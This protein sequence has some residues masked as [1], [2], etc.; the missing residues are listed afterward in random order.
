MALIL[1]VD[2]SVDN[3]M[4]MEEFLHGLEHGCRLATSG[5]MAMELLAQETFALIITDFQMEK[6]DGLWLLRKLK[7]F[8]GAPQCIMVTNDPRYDCEYF[9]NN[10]AIAHFSRPIIW[11]KLK[12]EINRLL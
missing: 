1:V 4:V 3:L 8:V 12:H 5:E 9:L 7:E 6:G 10:G 11:E 2:D